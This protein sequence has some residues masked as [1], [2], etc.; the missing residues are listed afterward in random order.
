MDDDNCDH[1]IFYHV[2]HFDMIYLILENVF[3]WFNLTS[4]MFLNYFFLDLVDLTTSHTDARYFD[5]FL[6]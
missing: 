1:L 5:V 6:W 4:V 2:I 3:M